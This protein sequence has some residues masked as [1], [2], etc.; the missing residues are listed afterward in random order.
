MISIKDF[1]QKLDLPD[2]TFLGTKIF[3]KQFYDNTSLT[4]QDKLAFKE[5]IES[6]IWRNTLKPNTI[7][8]APYKHTALE[9]KLEANTENRIED[10]TESNDEYLIEYLEV[11]VIEVSLKKIKRYKRLAEI[12]QRAIP[13]PTMIV[14]VFSETLSNQN[15]E[16]NSETDINKQIKEQT[17][18]QKLSIALNL[19]TKRISMSDSSKLTVERFYNTDWLLFDNLNETTDIFL[20]SLCINKQSLI[21][22]YEFYFSWINQFIKFETA[23]HTGIFDTNDDFKGATDTKNASLVLEQ[24]VSLENKL[25]TIKNNI[26]KEHQINRKVEMNIQAQQI[27]SELT[28][29]K[30]QLT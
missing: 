21:N 13:Y 29:L 10:S 22:F 4:S 23:R 16:T 3:K 14:F 28:E 11:A 27:Q 30:S 8:I 2:A 6:I 24:I 20:N 19:A 25:Q 9:S 12:I 18:I 1:Y 7:N 15:T 26:K 5:D 17:E